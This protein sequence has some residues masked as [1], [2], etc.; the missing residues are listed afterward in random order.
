M[1]KSFPLTPKTFTQILLPLQS[2]FTLIPYLLVRFFMNQKKH[3]KDKK[4][5]KTFFA[6][7]VFLTLLTGC[8]KSENTNT[9]AEIIG[10]NLKKRK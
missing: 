10:K 3:F 9:V 2:I 1:Q 6:V 7:L 4:M 5:R 8:F